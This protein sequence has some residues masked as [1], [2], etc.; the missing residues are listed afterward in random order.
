MKRMFAMQ[1]M[2]CM[3]VLAAGQSFAD[4][5]IKNRVTADSLEKFQAV[6]ADIR[7]D[8]D[9]GG[10]YEYITPDNKAKVESDLTEMTQMLKKGSV[11]ALSEADKLK[12]F[13]TQEHLNGLLTH[14]DSNRLI[15]ERVAPVGTTIPKTTCQTV[16]E[17]ERNRRAGQNSIKQAGVAGSTCVHNCRSN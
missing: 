12:L 11:S 2:L 1:G 15:C 3:L 9:G 10:R 16:A 13:N 4:D 5:A 8:M 6:A 14:S 17:I 7:K